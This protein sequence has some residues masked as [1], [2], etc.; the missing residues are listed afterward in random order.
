MK[1]FIHR[2]GFLGT[3]ASGMA[4]AVSVPS[5]LAAAAS[6]EDPVLPLYRKWAASRMEWYRW[7]DA[8][9]NG[10]YDR[11]ESIA[12]EE[13]LD[14]AFWA[15]IDTTPTTR[16]GIAALLVVLWDLTGPGC[17]KDT[18]EFIEEMEHSHNRLM[19]SIWRGATRLSGLPPSGKL[20]D[21]FDFLRSGSTENV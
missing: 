16:A 15:I 13:Q 5:A 18:P 6:P 2:R 21:G 12:A 14:E 8:P 20:E 17:L 10:N 4:A 1:R 19:A 11:P 3:A 9:G 7:A